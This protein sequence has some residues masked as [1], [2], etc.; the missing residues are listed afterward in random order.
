MFI[1]IINARDGKEHLKPGDVFGDPRM[2]FPDPP[3][4]Y[5]IEPSDWRPAPG[6]PGAMITDKE[7]VPLRIVRVEDIFLSA[8]VL[9][10]AP[11]GAREWVPLI[12]RYFHPTHPLQRVGFIPT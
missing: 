12:I 4:P 1:N 6:L 8:R 10:E 11:W 3:P 2:I 7:D 5:R 9:V